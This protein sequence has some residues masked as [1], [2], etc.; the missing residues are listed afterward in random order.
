MDDPILHRE[1]RRNVD[2]PDTSYD[3]IQ[4]SPDAKRGLL[5]LS[6]AAK[7][8]AD[9]AR[10]V[11]A[12]EVQVVVA[13]QR[14]LAQMA[15]ADVRDTQAR[16]EEG[17]PR[18]ERRSLR[19]RLRRLTRLTRVDETLPPRVLPGAQAR[20]PALTRPADKL[21]D[22]LPGSFHGRPSPIWAALAGLL[23]LVV[24]T[25]LALT[26]LPPRGRGPDRALPQP[27]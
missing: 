25:A 16:L 20:A 21:V 6:V 8:P 17:P 26:F 11:N 18:L 1:M 22:D 10:F 2:F 27:D 9:A 24:L 12:L 14:Q 19:R 3:D 23:V 4:V 15:G 5:R 13:T 7:T